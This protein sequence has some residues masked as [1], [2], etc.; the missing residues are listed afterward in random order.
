MTPSVRH[1]IYVLLCVSLYGCHS[2]GNSLTVQLSRLRIGMKLDDALKLCRDV[3]LQPIDVL[4]ATEAPPPVTHLQQFRIDREECSDAFVIAAYRCSKDEAFIVHS[5]YWHKDFRG[6]FGPIKNRKA[7]INTDKF[8]AI[9]LVDVVS[10][11]EGKM[12]EEKG[13]AE[14]GTGPYNP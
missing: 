7:K 2:P 1:G 8:L 11:L 13:G 9:D 3:G 12:G 5:L 14:K 4:G 10:R 6:D